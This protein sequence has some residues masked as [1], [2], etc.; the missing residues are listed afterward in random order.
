MSDML[1]YLKW[2]GDILFSQL[3]VNP[4]DALVFSTLSYISYDG[5]IADTPEDGQRLRDVAKTIL[6]QPSPGRTPWGSQDTKLLQ[7]AANTERFGNARLTAYRDIFIPEEETQFAAITF[8]L[9]DGSAFLS[10]RGTDSTLVGWKEDFNMSFQDSVPAQR[11]AR[12]YVH[13]FAAFSPAALWLGGHSKGG[14][15]AVYGAA[16]S[17][18]SVQDR[19]EAVFNHDG[20][21]F[22]EQ[23]LLDPNY[24]NIVPKIRTYVPQSSIFGMLLEHEEPYIVIKS[25]QV[26]LMQHNPHNWEILGPDF[27]PGSG[28]TADS[29]FLDRTFKAWLSGMSNQDRN[30]FFDTIYELL[31]V[32]NASSPRDIIRPQNIRLYL[33]TLKTDDTMRRL[34]ASELVSLIQS[35]IDSQ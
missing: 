11:L 27:I 12:E 10:F 13:D 16:K 20:P 18:A 26:G 2:R 5:I 24:L 6:D 33:K 31:T 21:G 7:A 17:E 14:N 4:V 23:M 9:D 1:D 30:E 35:A 15:L 19:I 29:L 22:R 3:P 34:I 8:L 25:K 28:L 32:G